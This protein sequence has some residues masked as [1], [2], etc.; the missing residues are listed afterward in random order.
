MSKNIFKIK[1]ITEMYK[2]ENIDCFDVTFETDSGDIKEWQFYGEELRQTFNQFGV[3][4]AM[5]V[6]DKTIS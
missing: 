5:R 2:E 1:K 4:Y 6:N 3:G